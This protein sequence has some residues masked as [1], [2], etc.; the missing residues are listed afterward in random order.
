MENY[1]Q[2]IK[3]S[4][5]NIIGTGTSLKRKRKT[6]DDIKKETFEKII[7]TMEE[8]QTRSNL[9]HTDFGLDYYSYDEK[10]YEVIDRLFSLHFGREA[11][12]VIFFYIYEKLNADGSINYLLDEENNPVPLENP[13]D[14][15]YVVNHISNNKS[16]K[17]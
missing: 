10:F 13:T 15:W 4:I 6:E 17:K 7:L 2:G 12:E 16:K 11:A 5:E 3:T 14:L 9:M 1:T 8:I